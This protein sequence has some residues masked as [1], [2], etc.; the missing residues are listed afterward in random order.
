MRTRKSDAERAD[1]LEIR[2]AALRQRD[3]GR[4]AVEAGGIAALA[5]HARRALMNLRNALPAGDDYAAWALEQADRATDIR[6]AAMEK[7]P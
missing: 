2:A 6:N 4:R 3:A 1:D 7:K 5:E